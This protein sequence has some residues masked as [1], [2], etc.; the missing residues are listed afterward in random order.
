MKKL[1]SFIILLTC[2]LLLLPLSLW[3]ILIFI[4]RVEVLC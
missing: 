4:K 3:L 1:L 2:L